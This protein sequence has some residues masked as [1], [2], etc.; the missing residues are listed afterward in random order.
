MGARHLGAISDTL[1]KSVL[2]YHNWQMFYQSAA[3]GHALS[4]TQLRKFRD[5]T[6]RSRTGPSK[7][8]HL[9]RTLR[10]DPKLLVQ[11]IVLRGVRFV[12][13]IRNDE[14]PAIAAGY[15][16]G[17]RWMKILAPGRVER[18]VVVAYDGSKVRQ[19]LNPLADAGIVAGGNFQRQPT[20]RQLLQCLQLR[21]VLRLDHVRD[22]LGRVGFLQQKHQHIQHGEDGPIERTQPI[23]NQFAAEQHGKDVV[24]R[25]QA[26]SDEISEDRCHKDRQHRL[27]V[28]V[29]QIGRVQRRVGRNVVDPLVRCVL[30]GEHS[31]QEPI[32]RTTENAI[33][34]VKVRHERV[35]QRL[36]PKAVKIGHLVELK[37]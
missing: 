22:D 34:P 6:W 33:V 28:D 13:F 23:V 14:R 8:C 3:L 15:D 27:S 31:L 4:C 37:Q 16:V 7:A 17:E 2:S 25:E 20:A 19:V 36:V 26:W 11:Q 21:F 24:D 18:A 35:V 5:V 9:G 10:R 29:V 12:H 32:I 1:E 30:M